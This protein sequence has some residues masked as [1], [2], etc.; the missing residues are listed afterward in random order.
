MTRQTQLSTFCVIAALALLAGGC[1]N[2]APLPEASPPQERF[3]REFI[4]LLQ[5]SG[6]TAVL[7]LTSPNTRA[8]KNFAQNMDIL[9]GELAASH[10]TLAPAFWKAVPQKDGG[11]PVM[12]IVYRVQGAGG[13]SELKLWIEEVAGHY[14]LNTIAVGP[15]NPAGT[16]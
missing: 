14:L 1:R 10:A 11:S 4:R 2:T 13:P 3:A 9:R 6:S 7:S 5:D 15:P 8:L 16:E 12:Q